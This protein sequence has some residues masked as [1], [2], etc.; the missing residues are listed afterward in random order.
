MALLTLSENKT[1]IYIYKDFGWVEIY[2]V[3]SAAGKVSPARRQSLL[4]DFKGY[5]EIDGS[6]H[7]IGIIQRLCLRNCTR[8][9]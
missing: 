1:R 6:I 3:D 2:V 4:D 5:I 8:K 7:T 9:T